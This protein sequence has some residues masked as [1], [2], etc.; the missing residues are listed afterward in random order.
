M[1]EKNGYAGKIGNTGAQKVKAPYP[2][3]KKA[4][5]ATV[6]RGEDLRNGG[7]K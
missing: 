2:A 7:K 1:A 3:G 6:K 4:G 5:K